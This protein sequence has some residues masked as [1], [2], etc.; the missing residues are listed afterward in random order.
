V[1]AQVQSVRTELRKARGLARAGH[2]PERLV[3]LINALRPAEIADLLQALP[4]PDRRW[5]WRLVE[6]SARGRVLSELSREA[7]RELLR[8]P[9][10]RSD[11]AWL[12]AG[13]RA[14]D[15]DDLADLTEDLP[16]TVVRHVLASLG[17]ADRQRL[18]RALR[19]P[20][21]SAG[22][23]MN[24]DVISVRPDVTVEVVLR[25]LRMRRPLPSELDTLLVVDR[26]QRFLGALALERLATA[27]PQKMAGDLLDARAPVVSPNAPAREVAQLFA[28]LD[29]TSLAVVG[30]GGRLLGRITADD[31]VDAIRE[32]AEATVRRLGHLPARGDFFSSVVRTVAQ[33]SGWLAFGLFGAA[34]TALIVAQFEETIRRATAVAVLMPMVA[35]LGGVLAMQT[36]TLTVRGL[37]L[38][39]IGPHNR[40]RLLIREFFIALLV[41][42]ALA[43]IFWA[44]TAWWLSSIPLAVTGASALVLTLM[45][46]AVLGV[47]VPLFLQRIGLDP[48]FSTSAMTAATD[49]IAYGSVLALTAAAIYR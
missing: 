24:P 48:A 31:V 2:A 12:L 41:S 47:S 6:S 34:M 27:K 38:G 8:S 13:A 3:S 20:A 28:D 11:F 44:A 1:N 25:Y 17:R 49:G 29:L 23:L 21:D 26:R 4:P 10:G 43:A 19:Y 9:E 39:Q 5:I 15:I 32:D 40:A 30:R 7:R 42:G 33:R 37:A 22:G 18:H 35:S 36:A 46:A 16:E 14:M 45:L